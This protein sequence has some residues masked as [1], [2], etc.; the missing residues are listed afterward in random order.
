MLRWKGWELQGRD[1]KD[2]NSGPG[3]QGWKLKVEM[4]RMRASTSR[5]QGWEFKGQDGALSRDDNNF[6]L[7]CH[8]HDHLN[9]RISNFS[10]IYHLT[11][12]RHHITFYSENISQPHDERQCSCME[13]NCLA[14]YGIIPLLLAGICF[15]FKIE[16]SSP[17]VI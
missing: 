14:R 1:S 16:M 12:H 4:I 10:Y 5:C 2:E 6:L 15:D 11:S 9:R 17:S 13:P 7:H 8:W 3:W